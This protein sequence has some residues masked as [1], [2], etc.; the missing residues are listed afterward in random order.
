MT[1][2]RCCELLLGPQPV[3]GGVARL[4]PLPEQVRQGRDVIRLDGHELSLF[5]A[6][7]VAAAVFFFVAGFGVDAVAL[8]REGRLAVVLPAAA[9][10]SASVVFL[11]ARG[12][13]G[14]SSAIGYLLGFPF[15]RMEATPIVG[16]R[17]LRRKWYLAGRSALGSSPGPSVSPA[18]TR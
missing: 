10:F 9:S 12:A 6:R 7:D 1:P 8:A 18:P 4:A 15:A 17:P 14:F 5:L 13:R 16:R 3:L 11:R 2:L